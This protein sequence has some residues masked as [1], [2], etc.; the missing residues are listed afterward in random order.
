MPQA[1]LL[2]CPPR[3]QLVSL[4][5]SREWAGTHPFIRQILLTPCIYL[6]N[7]NF[8]FNKKNF[9]ITYKSIDDNIVLTS[10]SI[11]KGLLRIT[12]K[13]IK[14][15]GILPKATKVKFN[16]IKLWRS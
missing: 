9:F 8:K 1:P 4:Q 16:L 11:L 12:S 14:K 6:L 2:E 7:L 3:K 13:F 5:A 15:G 10:Q